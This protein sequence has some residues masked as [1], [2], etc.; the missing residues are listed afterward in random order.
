M[1]VREKELFFIELFDF[2]KEKNSFGVA[3][4]S[5]CSNSKKIFGRIFLL[6]SLLELFFLG[7]LSKKWL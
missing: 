5:Y 1:S 2:L 4:E 6:E 7:L 3:T